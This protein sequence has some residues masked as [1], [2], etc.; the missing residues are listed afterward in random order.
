[1]KVVLF[2]VARLLAGLA[3]CVAAAFLAVTY[4][5]PQ[6]WHAFIPLGFAVVLV[7]LA[8]RYGLLVSLLGAPVTAL[9]FAYFL[10]APLHS[11]RVQDE[12]H[13]AMLGWMMLGSIVIS[14]FLA[15]RSRS[16]RQK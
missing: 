12:S 1:M 14:F 11:F 8:A 10:Y 5:T 13:R 4:P 15:P 2:R 16:Q 3:L 9:I 7:L 6:P